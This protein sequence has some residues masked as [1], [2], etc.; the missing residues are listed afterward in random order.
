MVGRWAK[1]ILGIL[2]GIVG[3]SILWWQMSEVQSM[4]RLNGV[5]YHITVMRTEAEREKGLSGTDSLP[6]GNAMVF[7]FPHSDK[8]RVWMKDMNYPIDIV[9]VNDAGQ[10]VH[11]VS[12]AQPSSYPKTMFEP[13]TPARYVIEFPAG[14]VEKTAIQKGSPVG[15]PSGV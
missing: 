1:P 15:L 9:W 7:V 14:T 13:P 10:V 5:R 3:L 2:A 8:W 11:T 12:N 6:Q 4:V